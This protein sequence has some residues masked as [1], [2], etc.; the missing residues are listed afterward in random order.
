M[1]GPGQ[2]EC[3]KCR[4]WGNVDPTG[5]IGSCLARGGNTTIS[6]ERAKELVALTIAPNLD[7]ALRSPLAS[8]PPG[9]FWFE[10]CIHDFC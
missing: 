5:T 6:D 4:C 7:A 2:Q 3:S 8:Y 10:W 1:P 9:K